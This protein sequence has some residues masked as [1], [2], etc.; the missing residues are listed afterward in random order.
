M[1]LKKANPK[2]LLLIL[3]FS[4]L[5]GC[6]G[7][8]VEYRPKGKQTYD[9]I[10][11]YTSRIS[12]DGV[13]LPKIYK[14]NFEWTA[15]KYNSLAR[16]MGLIPYHEFDPIA[17]KQKVMEDKG[18]TEEQA[19]QFIK[20]IEKSRST[21]AKHNWQPPPDAPYKTFQN[22]YGQSWGFS[23]QMAREGRTGHPFCYASPLYEDFEAQ[24]VLAQRL[25]DEIHP[26]CK[27]VK[28]DPE[29]LLQ[30]SANKPIDPKAYF[31]KKSQLMAEVACKE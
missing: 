12:K 11:V 22:Q 26:G 8:M 13:D 18:A 31:S 28:I 7:P 29:E 14:F 2:I 9:D 3:C 15:P 17:A 10:I 25:L 27:I 23:C 5:S 24:R 6:V 21:L 20:R 1:L 16:D 30:L 19:A 4:F